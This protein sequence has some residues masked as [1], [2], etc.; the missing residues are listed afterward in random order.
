MARHRARSTLRPD[1]HGKGPESGIAGPAAALQAP[2]PAL[3]GQA[4][5]RRVAGAASGA[6]QRT[7][8]LQGQDQERCSVQERCRSRI[9]SVA[10]YRIVAQDF[11]PKW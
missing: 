8:A 2:T 11:E 4:A 6:L 10:A 3:Q 5:Y 9:R 1:L 7:A